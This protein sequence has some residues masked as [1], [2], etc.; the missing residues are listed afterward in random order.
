MGACGIVGCEGDHPYT[1][2][3]PHG[4]PYYG[5]PPQQRRDKPL[6]VERRIDAA[7]AQRALDREIWE[8]KQRQAA[9]AR[10][11]TWAKTSAKPQQTHIQRWAQQAAEYEADSPEVERVVEGMRVTGYHAAKARHRA[12]RG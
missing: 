2:G 11:H 12:R 5:R 7:E 6:S 10:E 3:Y 1:E 9:E 8:G 4:C